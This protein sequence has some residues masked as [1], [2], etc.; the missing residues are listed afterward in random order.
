MCNAFGIVNYEGPNV[1]VKGMEDYRPVSAFS[2]LGRYR[3][4]DFPI[5]NMSNS[6]VNH[7]KVFVKTNPRSLKMCIRDRILIVLRMVFKEAI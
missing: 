3:L 1:N 2:F 7:I 5:S 4:I 6:G